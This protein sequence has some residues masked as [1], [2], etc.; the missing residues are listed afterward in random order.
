MWNNL[1]SWFQ[2]QVDEI[3]SD[4]LLRIYGAFL[5][6][7][8]LATY[9]FWRNLIPSQFENRPTFICW[10]FFPG[11]EN[12]PFLAL[13]LFGSYAY[14]VITLALTLTTAVYFLLGRIK[15]AWILLALI[16]FMKAAW[17]SSEY[18]RMGNFHYMPYVIAAA[19]LFVPRKRDTIICFLALFYLFAGFLKLNPEWLS[20]IALNHD[21]PY[22]PRHLHF[23]LLG[24]VVVLELI[25][26]FA[27]LSQKKKLVIFATAQFFL[28]HAVS[29]YFVGYFYPIVMFGLLAIFPLWLM[30]KNFRTPQLRSL[31]RFSQAAI[32]VFILAQLFPL[33]AGKDPALHTN[34][35]LTALNMFDAAVLCEP[36]FHIRRK[37]EIVEYIP[38]YHARYGLRVRCDPIVVIGEAKSLCRENA[39][40]P[41]FLTVDAFLV[42]RRGTGKVYEQTLEAI[43]VCGRLGEK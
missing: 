3:A 33:A 6:V 2:G 36:T 25:F 5:T 8:I 24:Y 28:F 17:Q 1:R 19:F 35:R 41:K 7:P 29:W 40:D 16:Y 11:C 14:W 9:V 26:S 13:G 10:P 12:H 18:L 31:P 38:E 32:F 37:D 21:I 30:E 22:I 42:A 34:L 4:K 39:T 23:L 43:D 20:G 15:A 27:L